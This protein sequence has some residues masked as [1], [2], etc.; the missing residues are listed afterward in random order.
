MTEDR[1]QRHGL[2]L[3]RNYFKAEDEA[4]SGQ[5]SND[6]DKLTNMSDV[7]YHSV[8]SRKD[9]AKLRRHR[10]LVTLGW[11]LFLGF[12]AA[13]FFI[14][15][16]PPLPGITPLTVK[17]AGMIAVG[18]IYVLCII[19]ALSDNM[20]DGLLAIV[21][22]FYPIYYLFFVSGSIFL[23]AVSAALLV[24]FGFD[25]LLLLQNLALKAIDRISYWIANT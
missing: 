4:I 15:F 21:V 12:T 3:S 2:K 9:L 23:R 25:C 8:T 18:V 14:R 11:L 10:L 6:E 24:V 22:P 7:R 16:G 19:L 17:H 5:P 20:F 1:K 13:L